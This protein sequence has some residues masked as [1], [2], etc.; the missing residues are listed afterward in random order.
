MLFRSRSITVDA[1]LRDLASGNPRARAL[2]AERLGSA[3]DDRRDA[4]ADALTR[5]LRDPRPEIRA[6]ACVSLGQLRAEDAAGPLAACLEDTDS[7]VRQCAAIALGEIGDDAGFAPLA[8]ALAEGPADLRFQAATS[9]V[10]IDAER[11]YEPLIAALEDDDGEVLGAVALSLGAIGDRRAGAHLAP[12]LEHHRR[13]TRFEAAYALAQ[14]GDP[15]AAPVLGAFLTAEAT[16]W[17]AASALELLG[18]AGA[19]PLAEVLTSDARLPPRI[20]LRIAGA[21]LAAAPDHP[22]APRA[23]DLLADGLRLRKLEERGVAVSELARVGGP[24]ALPPLRELRRRRA[25]RA[26]AEDID[27]ALAAIAAQDA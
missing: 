5:V 20:A 13:E 15:R 6:A 19:A 2:A 23:R 1:A 17:D 18:D 10:E 3:G 16:G 14:L 22:S 11:A 7:A 9:L 24:W 21:L 25:G 4:A 12:L 8:A 26:L 27:D